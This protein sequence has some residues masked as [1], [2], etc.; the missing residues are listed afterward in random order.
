[1]SESP[2]DQ[3]ALALSNIGFP[4]E[5][6]EGWTAYPIESPGIID[7]QANVV[8][9]GTVCVDAVTV[10]KIQQEWFGRYG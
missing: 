4:D 2:A 6:L 10:P 7:G 5:G 8:Q 1:M 3:T 9:I